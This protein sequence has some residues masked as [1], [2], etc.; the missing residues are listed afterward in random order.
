MDCQGVSERLPW[1]LNG[2]LSAA[3]AQDVRA[4]LADCARCREELDETRRAAAVFDVHVPT[5]AILDLAW[6]RSVD[7]LVRTHLDACA[8]CR[9]EL[10]LARESRRL[11]EEAPGARVRRLPVGFLLP[12][13]LAAGLVVGFAVGGRRTVTPT[14]TL[15]SPDPLTANAEAE[16]ARLRQLVAR[17][18]AEAQTARP[19]INLPLFE[20]MPGLVRRGGTGGATE[21]AIPAHAKEVALLLGTGTPSGTTAGLA[22]EDASGRSIWKEQGLVSGPPGGYVV[23]VP[24]EMLPPGYYVIR[25]RPNKGAPLE[26][27]IR[28]RR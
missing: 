1:L 19:R 16:Y 8:A 15:P 11:D 22:I 4:H 25:L 20:L 24:A 27:G 17:L 13:T 23:T 28:V 5:S 18:E 7:D 10:D 26:Y 21:I 9:E 3:E 2:S 12:L 14:S 6:G